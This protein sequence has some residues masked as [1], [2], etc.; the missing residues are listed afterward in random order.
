[1]SSKLAKSAAVMSVA[2]LTSRVLGIARDTVLARTFGAGAT[3]DAFLVAFRVPNLLRDLFAEGA[4]TAAFVPT[5]TRALHTRGKDEA[6]RVGNLVLN[7]LLLVTG[8]LVVLGMFVAEP[9]TLM[10]A[11]EYRDDQHWLDITATMTKIML[12]FLPA[13][14][15]AVAMMGMLNSLRKFFIPALSPAMFNVATI[16]CALAA[17]PVMPMFGLEP[18]LGLAIGTLIGGL[19]QILMQWPSLRAEGFRYRPIL[20]FKDPDVRE[21]LRLMGPGTIGVAAAPINVLVNTYLA[22]AEGEGA[23]SWLTYAFRL[24]YLPIGIFGVSVA[25]AALPDLSR[26]FGE[27]DTPGMRRTLSSALRLMLVMN[28]PAMV[29]LMVLAYPI[30]ELVLQYDAFTAD[31]TRATALALMFYAPGLLGYS[32]VKII[33]PA[34]YAMKDSRTPVAVSLASVGVNL[35]LNLM[36][37]R[38]LGYRG[39]ALGTAIAAIMN[40]GVLLW[41][42]RGRV[43]GIDGRALLTSFLKIAVASAVMGVVAYASFAWLATALPDDAVVFRAVRVFGAIGVAL[44][45]L[46]ISAQL[47]HIEEFKDAAARVLKRVRR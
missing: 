4:M 21:I 47:L 9:L 7:A 35:V 3:M 41:I 37:V 45:A 43:H 25:T 11:G 6:W 30:V 15:I 36:L 33:S 28:V 39:L 13:I 8:V 22:L 19:G 2:T 1:M 34:F 17:V 31:D 44:G 40:A 32:A 16:A 12:P 18:V 5:F 26:Q 46:A 27:G 29:G 24:M 10:L 42:F 14:A 23:V 20:S 38:V